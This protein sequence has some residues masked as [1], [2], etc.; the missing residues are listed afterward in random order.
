VPL[1]LDAGS[2]DQ[3]LQTDFA[4]DAVDFLLGNPLRH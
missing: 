4:F 2:F 1:Q 3:P